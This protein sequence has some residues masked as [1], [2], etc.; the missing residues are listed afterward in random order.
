[1]PI[2]RKSRK[3]TS[4]YRGHRTMGRGKKAG[5]GKGKRGGTGNAGL[6]KHKYLH[7]VIYD[8]LHFGV[9]GFTL[10]DEAAHPQASIN[11]QQLEERWAGLAGSA[12]GPLDLGAHGIDKLLGGGRVSTPM[13]VRVKWASPRAVDKIKAAGGKVEATQRRQADIRAEA[14][15]AAEAKAKAAAKGGGGQ[16]APKK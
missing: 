16:Q 10:P 6:H 12:A 13:Q 7:T 8:P 2:H 5:R 11:V 1:M 15:K 9:H 14:R 4:K 3:T